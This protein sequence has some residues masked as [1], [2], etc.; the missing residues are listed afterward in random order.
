M[1]ILTAQLDTQ[2][3]SLD[4]IRTNVFLNF[5]LT[6]LK[7]PYYFARWSSCAK[8][9]QG[10]GRGQD[11]IAMAAVKGPP[12]GDALVEEVRRR[13]GMIACKLRNVQEARGGRLDAARAAAS[14]GGCRRLS[15]IS[16]II[17]AMSA[18]CWQ[19]SVLYPM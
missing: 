9:S 8:G 11:T 2:H 18:Q 17:L 10:R 5:A 16:A 19:R 7:V 6:G 13:A 1:E 14:F 15:K 3:N 4:T 12:Q